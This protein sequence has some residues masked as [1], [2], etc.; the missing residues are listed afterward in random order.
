MMTIIMMKG[1]ADLFA[2]KSFGRVK[3]LDESRRVSD[4]KSIT[5]GARQHA[6]HRQPDVAKALW[7]VPAITNTEHV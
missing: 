2:I 1:I 5:N 4:E 6:G 3:R 7:G